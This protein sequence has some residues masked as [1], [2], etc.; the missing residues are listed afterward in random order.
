[1]LLFNKQIKNINK[2]L[3]KIKMLKTIR[4]VKLWLAV[5]SLVVFAVSGYFVAQKSAYVE[6]LFP[7]YFFPPQIEDDGLHGSNYCNSEVIEY[8]GTLT[9]NIINYVGGAKPKFIFNSRILEQQLKTK[10]RLEFEN[11]LIKLMSFKI[12]NPLAGYFVDTLEVTSVNKSEGELSNVYATVSTGGA[13][14]QIVIESIG[15]KLIFP[16]NKYI[17][18]SALIDIYAT[19]NGPGNPG[20]VTVT[21]DS[22]G[23]Y[24]NAVDCKELVNEI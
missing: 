20:G 11:K 21:L 22:F 9:G 19:Y 7:P 17:N 15:G 14:K 4:N 24:Y 16:V 6:A 8:S 12:T 5:L 3:T 1:M 10:G 2:N 23:D 18:S 13:R